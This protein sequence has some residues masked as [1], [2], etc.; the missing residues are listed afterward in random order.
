MKKS[1][2]LFGILKI[3]FDYFMCV[4]AFLIA[5]RLRTITMIGPFELPVDLSTFPEMGMYMDF[6]LRASVVL[7]VLFALNRMYSLKISTKISREI[8]KVIVLSTYWLMILITYFFIIREFPFSRLAIG[9]TWVLAF[10][11]V[12]F[13]RII[14]RILQNLL[15]KVGVGMRRVLLIGNNKVALEL[16]KILLKTKQVGIIETIGA[17]DIHELERL[18]KKGRI[19][20][21]IQTESNLSEIQNSKILD[22]CREHHIQY[23]FVPDI[24]QVQKTNIEMAS[25]G[26]IPLITLRPT[27][28]DG[29]GRVM[30]RLFDVLG[31][32]IGLIVFSPIFLITSIL[33][34]IDSKGTVI[35]RFLDDEK[36][37]KRVGERGKLFNFYKF[38]SMHPN[39]HNR[40]YTDLAENN[41]RKG[42]P[43]VKI[44][45]DPRI[46]RVGHYIRKWDIDELPSLWNVLKGDMS[47]VGPRPHLPEEVDNYEKHHKFVL[48]I[49]PGITGLAQISGRSDLNFEKE[50]KLDT[51]YIENWSIWMDL[52]IIFKTFT[53]VFKGKNND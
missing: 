44:K 8:W 29:W 15:L 10:T 7:I 28:L 33:I 49:K 4:L 53:V 21:I 32:I 19:E 35:F 30:K 9:Y 38:R 1:E 11:F 14:I 17:T 47:I 31:S 25:P 22:F 26:G 45:D 39:T 12:S 36:R 46:T 20:E 5:Y 42:T 18:I 34:K 41:K 37:V 27:R 51:Y 23:H 40:R 16:E 6:A 24:V 52:K 50:V 43:M 48:T 3:P 2:I 13:G